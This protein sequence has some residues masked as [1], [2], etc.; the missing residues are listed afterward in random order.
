MLLS[1]SNTYLKYLLISGKFGGSIHGIWG[2]SP[3]IEGTQYPLCSFFSFF[4]FFSSGPFDFED[5]SGRISFKG[6][7]LPLWLHK[8][9]EMNKEAKVSLCHSEEE[10]SCNL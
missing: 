8:R 7:H 6:K 4:L 9:T 2:N 3:D 10:L 5:E 1:Y